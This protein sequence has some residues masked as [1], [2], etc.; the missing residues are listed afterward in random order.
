[1][2]LAKSSERIFRHSS[3]EWKKLTWTRKKSNGFVF[4]YSTLFFL[5]PF[6]KTQETDEKNTEL[7]L[8]KVNLT[9]SLAPSNIRLWWK[10]NQLEMNSNSN[11]SR[12]R[13]DYLE[14]KKKKSWKLRWLAFIV[15]RFGISTL[16]FSVHSNIRRT[17]A[18]MHKP[19]WY[20]YSWS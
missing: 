20:W 12:I 19:Y 6:K 1:M 7:K 2:L 16:F 15:S 18:I 8:Q 4:V 17:S 11:C 13:M 14:R 10:K 3:G 9:F 5:R